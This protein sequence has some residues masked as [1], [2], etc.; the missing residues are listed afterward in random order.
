MT[1]KK[2]E[3]SGPGYLGS[4]VLIVVLVAVAYLVFIKNP[5][6]A[7]QF[8]ISS[9]LIE[10]NY[11]SCQLKGERTTD[12]KENNDKDKDNFPDDCDNC[13]LIGGNSNNDQ[14]SDGDYMPDACD[15]ERNK[16][17]TFSCKDGIKWSK[18]LI[19]LGRCV[20]TT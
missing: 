17:D 8:T 19:P 16:I 15:K 10:Q 14:D 11:K 2:G 1:R 3:M 13:I 7:A 5:S 9:T 18:K 4:I 6:Q 12:Y 20:Q